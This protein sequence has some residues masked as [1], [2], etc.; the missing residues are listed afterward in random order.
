MTPLLTPVS[1]PGS[2]PLFRYHPLHA[3]VVRPSRVSVAT[4]GPA[5]AQRGGRAFHGTVVADSLGEGTHI[6]K[7]RSSF[8]RGA[9]ASYPLLRHAV[10]VWMCGMQLSVSG[11]QQRLK[12]SATIETEKNPNPSSILISSDTHHSSFQPPKDSI[13]AV[14]VCCPPTHRCRP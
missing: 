6:E 9:G 4:A 10:Y 5:V 1:V 14:P 2:P 7:G 11:K 12:Q 13:S 3:V 8:E